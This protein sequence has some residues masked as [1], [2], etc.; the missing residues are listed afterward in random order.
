MLDLLTLIL[1]DSITY[2]NVVYVNETK[3]TVKVT[4]NCNYIFKYIHNCSSYLND[5][6]QRITFEF[7]IRI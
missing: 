4:G 7:F 6:W 3:A 1:N 5:K 2:K